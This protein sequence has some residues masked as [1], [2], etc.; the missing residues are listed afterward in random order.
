[1]AP[2]IAPSRKP[3][4]TSTA[5]A[6]LG[7]EAVESLRALALH[8]DASD[9]ARKA[10]VLE[11]CAR[12]AIAD[13]EVLVAYHDCL[14]CLLAYPQTRAL[15]DAA[16]SELRRVARAARTL[17]ERGPLRA[18]RKLANSGIA[19]SEVT[20]HFGWDI[21]RW[22]VERFPEHAEIDSF[23]E[24]GVALQSVLAAALPAIEFDLVAA[25]E[26]ALEFLERASAGHRGSRLSWLVAAFE[27]LACTDALREQ[28]FDALQPFTVLRPKGSPLSRTFVRGLPAPTFFH[29]ND[30]VRRVHLADLLATPLPP[31]RRLSA[32][33][34]LRVIDAGR[35]MLAAL[36]R[37]TDAIALASP[38]E[39]AWQE[40]GRGA[41]IALYPMRPE[42]R[43][44]LDSHV[45]MMLFKNG[46]PVGYGGG[47]PFGGTCRIGVNMFA[48]FRG[49]ESAYLF[50]Q[51][52]HVYGHRFR[53]DRFIAEPSQ[54]GGTN[55]EGLAS[56]AFWFYY[57]LGFRPIDARAARLA[58]D[59]YVRMQLDSGYRT[60]IPVL[61][62]FTQ[63]DIELR[64]RETTLACDPIRLSQAVSEWIADRFHGDRR[65]AEEVATSTLVR[66]LGASGHETLAHERK[67]CLPATRASVRTD[68]GTCA[69][70]RG[71]P[72]GTGDTDARQG[73]RRV[74]FPGTRRASSPAARCAGRSGND[75]FGV[76]ARATARTDVLPLRSGCPTSCA[77][78]QSRHRVR[79]LPF[80]GTRG[81]APRWPASALRRIPARWSCSST[82]PACWPT[83]RSATRTCAS[84]P[85]GCRRNTM[86]ASRAGAAAAF[87]SSTTWSA[88]PDRDSPTPIGSR[89]ATTFPSVRRGSS[90]KRR[91][92]PR[93]S[94]S[95]TA[96]PRSVATS[97]STRR[98]S[99]LTPT[100]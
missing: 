70:A 9:A 79:R 1:M 7:L 8:F 6:D 77:T 11:A 76:T 24:D 55:K 53:V 99:A 18:R 50:G 61:R 31:P 82:N 88:S 35:A 52:L 46:I 34:R 12:R 54:F 42:R 47:W 33:E 73:K 2:T 100:I 17:T 64:L 66:E 22:L 69:L 3:F 97:T 20:I 44:P 13:P 38:D 83:T 92:A 51:V 90:T 80:A 23:G 28:L 15:R 75:P 87:R 72:Q 85:S 95:P 71:G 27:R 93:S 29:R 94:S 49:G 21:V 65:A 14:L 96:S 91:W 19:W 48:P 4:P 10:R 43:S 86:T 74:S 68:S 26:S 78:A 58:S 81:R 67:T 39:V 98:R 45:G 63:G 32:S 62:R 5:G 40:V 37:E 56:G 16:R 59:E 25:E 41:A 30:L 60:P 89:S 84:S 57:R 36:G